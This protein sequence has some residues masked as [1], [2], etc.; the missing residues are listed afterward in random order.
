M[1]EEKEAQNEHVHKHMEPGQKVEAKAIV[2][3]CWRMGSG[4]GLTW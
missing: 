2:A 4:M 3:T 1:E